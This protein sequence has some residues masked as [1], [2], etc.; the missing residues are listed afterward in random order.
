MI[1]VQ[2]ISIPPEASP[3]QRVFTIEQWGKILIFWRIF[4]SEAKQCSPYLRKGVLPSGTLQGRR[5]EVSSI[6]WA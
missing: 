2:M 3:T 5:R 4:G 6:P 1:A